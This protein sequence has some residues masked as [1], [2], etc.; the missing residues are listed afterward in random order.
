MFFASRRRRGSDPWLDWKVRLFFM[1][2]ILAA[3]GI[4]SDRSWLVISAIV[5]LLAGVALR[6]LP[7][8]ETDEPDP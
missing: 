3:V 8:G 5:V 7:G 6:F 2:A 4:A 1:G